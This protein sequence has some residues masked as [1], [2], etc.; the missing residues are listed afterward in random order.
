MNPVAER[1]RR[2]MKK[3]ESLRK[4]GVD[5]QPVRID[6]RIFWADLATGEIFEFHL[7]QFPLDKLPNSLT[8]HGFGQD[9]DGE[10]Y[11]C[12]VGA[13]R[14]ATAAGT[15]ARHPPPSRSVRSTIPACPNSRAGGGCR[16]RSSPR[17]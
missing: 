14:C 6:G 13:G 3:M 1:R 5:V 15:R 4:K 17:R 11:L 10:L 12:S 7:P 8:V 16:S 9:S 2:A